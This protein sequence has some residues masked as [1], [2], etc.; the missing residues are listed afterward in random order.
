M[1]ENSTLPQRFHV[2]HRNH[3]DALTNDFFCSKRI[4][5]L[6]YN[7]LQHSISQKQPTVV[8]YRRAALKNFAKLTG[9]NLR[10][11]LSTYYFIEERL[12]HGCFPA[13]NAT[14][15]K[16]PI[17]ENICKRLLLYQ[18]SG[19]HIFNHSFTLLHITA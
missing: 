18:C 13:N 10:C 5:Y 2:S 4:I 19:T 14:F 16:T 7:Y 8:F 15:L 3:R 11:S 1:E 12:Q 9:K 6:N 17:L